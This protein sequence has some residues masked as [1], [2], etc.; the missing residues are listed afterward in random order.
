MILLKP[1][2]SYV[3]PEPRALEKMCTYE[4]QPPFG[5]LALSSH[6]LFG[7]VSALTEQGVD[8]LEYWLEGNPD[9]KV[10]LVVMVYPACATRQADL[11]R[12]L[13][14][15]ERLPDKLS[16]YIRPLERIT[17]RGSNALCFLTPDSDVAHIVTGPSEDLGLD[18]Q[19]KGQINFTLRADPALTEAFKRYFDWLWA[20]SRDLIAKGVALIPDLVLPEGTE[21]GAQQWQAY[22]D[23]CINAELPKYMRDVV[24]HVDPVTGD[25]K[26]CA[27]DGQE[28]APPTERLGLA[29]LD[30]LAEQMARLYDK[31]VLVSIDTKPYSA[32]GCPAEPELVW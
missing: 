5:E 7:I 27:E 13:K 16:V 29:K 18:S 8:V 11:L 32:S 22:V 19:Q 15:V 25:I 28:V 20:N 9:L 30:Q 21:E 17:D 4:Y 2:P 3:W 10:C 6:S 12:L 23:N 14:T 26:I 31:G 24:A 1:Q